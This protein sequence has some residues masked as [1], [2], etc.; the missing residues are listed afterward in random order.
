MML[1]PRPGILEI[2]PYVGG[3]SSAGAGVEPIKLSSNEAALG[4]SPKAM[5]V[6]AEMAAKLHRYPDGG[7]TDLRAAIAR[8]HDL[9]PARI[10]CSAG[11]DELIALLTKAYAGPG[12]EVLLSRHGFLMYPIAAHSVGATPVMA[13]ERN[14]T[15]DVDAML[16]H[17]TPKTRIVFLAN[18]NNPTGTYIPTSEVKRLHAALPSNVLFVLDAAYAEFVDADDYEAGARLVESS[19]NVVMLRTFSKLYG[20]AGLRLGWG[21]GSPAI[22][23][24]LNRV[25]GPFNV[26]LPAQAAGVA[27]LDDAEFTAR[28]L[29]HNAEWR[30]W[31]SGRLNQLGLDVVPSVGNFLLV[32]FPDKDGLRAPDA[33]AY[34]VSRGILVRRMDGYGLADSLRITIGKGP[35][36]EALA[37]ALADFLRGA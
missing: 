29:A 32:R 9:D 4:P 28:Q 3:K 36:N 23:D 15:T 8:H 34:L 27:A 31:L 19:D 18:P 10:V 37:A 35:E 14:L 1:E 30:A 11:S 7:S 26:S 13:P 25:R 20:L 17:V 12:D 5:A 16:A 21:Y 24:V 33:D 22:V 6:Y 2:A